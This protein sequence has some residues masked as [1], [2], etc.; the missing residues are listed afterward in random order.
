MSNDTPRPEEQ[1][2][3][4]GVSGYQWFVL[5]VASAG[6]VFDIYEG[7]IFALTAEQL[8]SDVLGTDDAAAIN[9][10]RDMLFGIF[11]VGGALG[12]VVFGSLADR[13][14]RLPALS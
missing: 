2:W 5:A 12:G 7:Q 3:Y 4:R 6:W 14:G 9:Y 1:P 11:L 10:Y 8:L 13:W